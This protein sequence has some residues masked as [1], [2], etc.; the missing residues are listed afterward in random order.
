[1]ACFGGGYGRADRLGISHLSDQYHVNILSEG[2]RE[3]FMKPFGVGSDLSFVNDGL[4]RLVD[5]FD[6]ILDGDD[7]FR[8]SFVYHLNHGSQGGGLTVADRTDDDEKTLLFIN[9][10]FKDRRKIQVQKP[11]H[12]LRDKPHGDAYY[13]AMKIRVASKTIA[14]LMAPRK[15]NLAVTQKDLEFFFGKKRFYD[16]L[17]FFRQDNFLFCQRNQITGNSY[18]RSPSR[19]D[20][21]IR[22]A[23]FYYRIKQ[24]VKFFSIVHVYSLLMIKNYLSR[25]PNF[26]GSFLFCR[27]LLCRIYKLHNF[28][29]DFG[30]NSVGFYQIPAD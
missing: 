6:R 17:G 9:E 22:R 7:V 13:S 26:L 30:R 25:L 3:R 10:C 18:D 16:R 4:F 19:G 1:M 5:I 28:P 2:R 11:L 29:Q 12:M 20:V 8:S 21:Q 15:I 27:G 24:I 23:F 14:S